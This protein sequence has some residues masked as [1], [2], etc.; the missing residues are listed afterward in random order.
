MTFRGDIVAAVDHGTWYVDEDRRLQPNR[1][2]DRPIVIFNSTD[3]QKYVCILQ[4][5]RGDDLLI[6]HCL[7]FH[8][9]HGE[10][11]SQ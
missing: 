7:F 11:T 10:V 4:A 8:T 1:H 9:A 5:P 6:F 3:V 2:R